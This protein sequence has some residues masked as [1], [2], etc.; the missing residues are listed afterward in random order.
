VRLLPPSEVEPTKSPPATPRLVSHTL[1]PG[2]PISVHY[3]DI[4]PPFF[5]SRSPKVPIYSFPRRSLNILEPWRSPLRLMLHSI[6][7]KAFLLP[8]IQSAISLRTSPLRTL[9]FLTNVACAPIEVPKF[10]S[11]ILVFQEVGSF[12]GSLLNYHLLSAFK[13]LCWRC[14]FSLE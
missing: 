6:F 14:F 11:T 9:A 13:L 7:L 2:L 4:T 12:F 8:S 1:T 3:H 10:P 5:L